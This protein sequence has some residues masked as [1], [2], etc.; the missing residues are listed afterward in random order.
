[1]NMLCHGVPRRPGIDPV[2]GWLIL[3]LARHGDVLPAYNAWEHCSWHDLP[4]PATLRAQPRTGILST[5]LSLS[6]V[7]T[8]HSSQMAFAECCCFQA[9]HGGRIGVKLCPR[10]DNVNQACFD[11]YPLFR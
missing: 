6:V 3:K 10:K 7:L 4:L 11:Q 8:N 9:N 2:F 5:R 1:M